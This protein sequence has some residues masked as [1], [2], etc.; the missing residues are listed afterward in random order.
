MIR[1]CRKPLIVMTPKSLLRHKMCTST[2]DDLAAGYYRRVLPE[3]DPIDP[4]KVN[5]IVLCYGK[6]YYELLEKR[7][8]DKR[9]DIAIIRLEQ[10][11]PFPGTDLNKVLE[12]YTNT[13]RLVW[14]QEEP[15]NQGCWDFAKPRIPAMLKRKWRLFYVGR[16]SSS[17]PAV[18]SAKLHAL[19]QRELVEKAI[20]FKAKNRT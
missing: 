1:M 7:R 15:K 20:N 5:H 16:E 11:Y 14:V 18:G 6:I 13:D 4:V 17:A 2:L 19:Q 8:L 12:C 3:I 9:D 10:M